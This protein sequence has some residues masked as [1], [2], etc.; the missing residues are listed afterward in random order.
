[1]TLP[2]DMDAKDQAEYIKLQRLSGAAFDREYV[3]DMVR[4]HE[5]DVKEFQKEANNGQNEQIKSFASRTLPVL[6]EHLSR[7]KSIQSG[8][9][10][11]GGK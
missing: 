3:K 10:S 4:D 5:E 2:T 7:I 1:M 9:Q 11:G 8:M 6:Q